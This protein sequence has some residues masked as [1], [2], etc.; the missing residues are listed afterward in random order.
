MF[1]PPPV[2]YARRVELTHV[3]PYGP[4]IGRRK[5]GTGFSYVDRETGDAVTDPT[6]LDRI[7]AIVVPPAW[8]DVWICA[9][10]DGHIQAVGTDA[11]GRRQY[12]YHEQWTRQ[13]HEE[14]F[15][16]VA[17]LG[18]VIPEVRTAIDGR[19]AAG[20]GLGRDRVLAGTVWMLDLGV[21]RVGGEEYA[22][23]SSPGDAS[24]GLATLRRE[25]AVARK[26]GGV[27]FRYTAKS[28][29]PRRI[30]LHDAHTHRLVT[31]LK[32]RRGGGEDLLAY[33]RGGSRGAWHDV[34]AED[35]NEAVRELVGD[36]FTAKDLRTWNA[37]VRA[38]VALAAEVGDDGRTPTAQRTLKA[39]VSRTMKTVAEQ[40]GNTPAVCRSSYV[41]PVLV[42][43]FEQGR[44]IVD[45][46]RGAAPDDPRM[47]PRIET[48]VRDLLAERG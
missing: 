25:H 17:R 38:A 14:K 42:T 26:D 18:A 43:A 8:K 30:T 6:T 5:R 33:R 36:E 47:R 23:S 29:V 19:L 37:G 1:I 46:V 24:F 16:R 28:G 3:E 13:Q 40:L 7:K 41:D 2:G 9:T 4:G 27:E 31:S 12:R 48:A 20:Q 21:F 15:Q 32:R 11:A 44:T 34:S 45:A 22:S 39:A 35:V 10:A